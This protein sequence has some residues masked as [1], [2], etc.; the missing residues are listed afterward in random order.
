M[1]LMMLGAAMGD[2]DHHP[3]RRRR[4]RARRIGRAGR[5][6]SR[7]GFGEETDA[8]RRSPPSPTRRSSGSARCAT[9]RRGASE[10]P[11]PRRGAADPH[12]SARQRP[13]ARDHRLFAAG[14][15]RTRWPPRS[16]PRPRRGR[17]RRSRP[18]PTSSRKMTR[19]GQS[20]GGARRLSP[21]RHRR[22]RRSTALPRRSGSSPRRCAIPAISAPSC[23][24]ATRSAP[25]G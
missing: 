19:Q 3:L 24:P 17:R 23:A 13:P 20:A 21:A 25:A 14:A 7:S 5:R 12:R 1:G 4:L 2:I 6:W 15:R 11:V 16:S 10:G 22:S 9:R 8:S 18:R